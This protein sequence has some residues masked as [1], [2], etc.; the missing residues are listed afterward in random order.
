MT[1]RTYTVEGMSCQ[2]CVN[3]I[4]SEVGQVPGVGEVQV[5]LE[6]GTVTVT[7]EQVDDAAVRAAVDEAG[8][9]V[10]GAAA[11]STP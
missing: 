1:S 7:G 8:Y 3:A 11:P 4:T 10:I 6:A 2:H 9:A 5:D